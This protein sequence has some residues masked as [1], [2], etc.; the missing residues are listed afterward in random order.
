MALDPYLVSPALIHTIEVLWRSHFYETIC[1]EYGGK[2]PNTSVKQSPQKEFLRAA[3]VGV[4]LI[5]ALA[6]YCVVNSEPLKK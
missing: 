3:L 6:N 1:V 4:L 5:F 2:K